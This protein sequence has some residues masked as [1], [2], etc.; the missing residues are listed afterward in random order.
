[1]FKSILKPEASVVSGI[2]TLGLVYAIYQTNVGSMAQA[3]ATTA[4]HP[5]LESSR[6][7]AGYQAFATVA[8]LSLITKD[9][10]IGILG[11]GGIIIMELIARHSI[12]ANPESGQIQNPDGNSAYAPAEN[13]IP[14]YQQGQAG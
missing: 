7:K 10:N 2:A 12:M 8:A 11:W 1:M 5:V 14:F 6:K 9:A 4:N 13:V 3:Q